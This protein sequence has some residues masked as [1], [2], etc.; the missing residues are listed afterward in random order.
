LFERMI[1]VAPNVMLRT[2]HR[3]HRGISRFPNARFYGGQLI[4]AGYLHGRPLPPY[5]DGLDTGHPFLTESRRLVFIDHD[6]PEGKRMPS[7]INESEADIIART[8][9][10][11]LLRFPTMPGTEIGVITPYAPQRRLLQRYISDYSESRPLLHARAR[12]VEVNTVDGFQ[13]R[14]VDVVLLSTVRSLPGNLAFISQSRRV[15]VACVA[16]IVLS[17]A[18][19]P[20]QTHPRTTRDHRRR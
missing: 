19:N 8:V 4:D 11:F 13:G 18:L 5:L 6:G 10:D 1:A 20:T 3:M 15:C 2:Q 7:R 14:E 16:P 9:I 12:D 17:V